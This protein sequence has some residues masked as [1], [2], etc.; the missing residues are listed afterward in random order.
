MIRN[1][2]IWLYDNEDD[3]DDDDTDVD[4][5]IMFRS[6]ELMIM[7]IMLIDNDFGNGVNQTCQHHHG[8]TKSFQTCHKKSPVC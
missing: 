7:V 6:V 4:M 2:P 3:D 1:T 8:N 5:L